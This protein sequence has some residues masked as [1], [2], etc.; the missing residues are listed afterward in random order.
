MERDLEE[1]KFKAFLK[2]R[3]FNEGLNRNFVYDAVADPGLP[4]PQSWEVLERYIIQRWSIDA[5]PEAN[6]A[7]KY[8]WELFLKESQ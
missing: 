2:K 3:T 8:V 5:L 7:A 1:N 6:D 4:D